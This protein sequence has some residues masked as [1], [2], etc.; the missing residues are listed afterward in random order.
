MT[1]PQHKRLHHTEYVPYASD[2][3][4]LQVNRNH[5]DCP[6]GL[7]T[8]AR[9]YIKRTEEGVVAYCHHCGKSGFFVNGS[10]R[11]RAPKH[12]EV[13]R[14][15]AEYITPKHMVPVRRNGTMN[16]AEL[17]KRDKAFSKGPLITFIEDPSV[18][19]T[20]LLWFIGDYNGACIGHQYRWLDGRKPKTKTYLKA[21]PSRGGWY[22]TPGI[23]GTCIIVEDPMSAIMVNAILGTNG[24]VHCLFGTKLTADAESLMNN[25]KRV[26][27]WLDPD[28]A[29]MNAAADI[30][31]RL[32]YRY[33]A[34]NVGL[35][36]PGYQPKDTPNMDKDIEEIL[37]V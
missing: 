11:V 3:V 10:S 26:I 25:F 13:Y 21:K 6:A 22:G 28:R 24:R 1:I 30:V 14:T 9:L 4:G 36:T 20:P 23:G 5:D 33:P 27:V 7:D 32:H 29:G 18:D 31:K 35:Y 8:K 34:I 15:D 17:I 12:V 19:G 37:R 2:T 16:G